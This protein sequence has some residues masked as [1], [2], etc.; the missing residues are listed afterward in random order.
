MINMPDD[1][2]S[3]KNNIKMYLMVY[4]D[5]LKQVSH[6]SFSMP[7]LPKALTGAAY[8]ILTNGFWRQ[9]FVIH[10]VLSNLYKIWVI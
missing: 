3:K 7:S 6:A 2:Y 4:A 9:N 5:F 10:G 8:F 1:E